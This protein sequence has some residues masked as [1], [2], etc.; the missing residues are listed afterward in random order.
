MIIINARFLTQKVTGVQRF[1]IELS[2]QLKKLSDDI[3]FVSPHNILDEALAAELGVV[4]IG[5][6]T[7]TTWE[8]I[9]LR[10]YLRSK[11]KPLLVNFCNT[12]IL[13]YSRQIVTIH[14]M[15]YKVNPAWFSKKFYRWYNFL[16]PHIAA[17]SRKIITVS[18]SSKNDIV[19]YLKIDVDKIAV[20]YNASYLNSHDQPQNIARKPYILTV[21]SLEPRKNLGRLIEASKQLNGDVKLVIVGLGN[22][23]TFSHD[24]NKAELAENIVIKGYVPD[25]ELAELMQF[26]RAFVYVSLY[27]GF[28]LPLVEAMAMHCPVIA[29]NIPVHQEICGNA[30]IY[31]D[32]YNVNDIGAGIQQLLD[33]NTLAETLAANGI[34]NVKRFSWAVS[35]KKTLDIINETLQGNN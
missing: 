32:P 35:A 16:I 7:G 27:E 18:N 22:T 28:G 10:K 12:G 30:A 25:N 2:K 29:S 13:Y 20:V 31:V 3:L 17:S 9:D 8:Q 14:D 33:N 24:F 6:R 23:K 21:S 11:H 1:A 5:K 4:I 19:K 34:E 15:S 26:A